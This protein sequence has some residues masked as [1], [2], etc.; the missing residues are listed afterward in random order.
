MILLIYVWSLL[1]KSSSVRLQSVHC[2]VRFVVWNSDRCRLRRKS[3]K[4]PGR[5]YA[6]NSAIL[7]DGLGN[8]IYSDL[9]FEILDGKLVDLFYAWWTSVCVNLV[10][11]NISAVDGEKLP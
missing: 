8:A 1:W 10:Q 6:D 3:W 11:M 5:I 4:N 2:I 9:M 7:D